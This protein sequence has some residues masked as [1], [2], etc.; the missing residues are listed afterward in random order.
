MPQLRPHAPPVHGALHRWEQIPK[1]SL[2]EVVGHA[3]NANG[4]KIELLAF[5]VATMTTFLA[6]DA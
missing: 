1:R 5:S 4:D 6:C 3:I 2:G